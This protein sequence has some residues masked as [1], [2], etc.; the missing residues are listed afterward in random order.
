[1]SIRL[2]FRTI[3]SLSLAL[4]AASPLY[5]SPVEG[6]SAPNDSTNQPPPFSAAENPNPAQSASDAAKNTGDAVQNSS[7]AVQNS[8][9]PPQTS[10]I[11]LSESAPSPAQDLLDQALSAPPPKRASFAKTLLDP[12]SSEQNLA[13]IDEWIKNTTIDHSKNLI[14]KDILMAMPAP[15]AGPRIVALALKSH[16]PNIQ[17]SYAR[18][19]AKYPDA[20]AIVLVGWMKQNDGNPPQML[21]YLDDFLSLKPH[22]AMD[23]WAQ[24]RANYPIAELGG[25]SGFGLQNPL[26]TRANI[27]ALRKAQNEISKLRIARAIVQCQNH[28]IAP[29]STSDPNADDIALIRSTAD[30]FHASTLPSRRIVALDLYALFFKG[31]SQVLDIVKKSFDDA[32]NTTEKSFALKALATLDPDRQAQNKRLVE[33]LSKGDETLRLAAATHIARDPNAFDASVLRNAFDKELWPETQTMLYS[34]I[35]ADVADAQA[36]Y[37]LQEAILL[38]ATR[39]ES[40]RRQVLDDIVAHSPQKLTVAMMAQIQSEDEPKLDLIASIAEALYRHQPKLRP[41]LRQWLKIQAPFERRIMATFARFVQIDKSS[42]DDSARDTMKTICGATPIQD[43]II[44]TCLD[45]YDDLTDTS[46]TENDIVKQLKSR[47][48]QIDQMLGFEL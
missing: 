5:A 42:N 38:D 31:D 23:I 9:A 43:G 36:R 47:Q 41:D 32:K 25:L 8:S 27:D 48:G 29:S 14:L 7:D 11:P 45:Y 30:A 37:A 4:L 1:M 33:A 19:L 24:L 6:T 2:I 13:A 39:A 21:R 28:D 35:A 3:A 15:I 12:E 16:D 44:R 26:C 17:D 40:L 22:Q 18:W 20:Y 34:A 46:E 10:N